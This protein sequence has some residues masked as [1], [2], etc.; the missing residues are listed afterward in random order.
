MNWRD[1]IVSDP[2]VL[3]GKPRGKG[4]RLG[5]AFLLGLFGAGWTMEQV[6]ENYPHL[7]EAGLHAVFAY[8]SEMLGEERAQ[9]A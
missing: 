2:Q 9:A 3:G 8:A 1:H 4:T 7:T 6:L 5:V